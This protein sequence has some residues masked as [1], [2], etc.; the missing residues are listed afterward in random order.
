MPPRSRK[1]ARPARK[2]AHGALNFCFLAG[3]IFGVILLH[4]PIK[5]LATDAQYLGR[6]RSIAAS[7]G[8]RLH[9]HSLFSFIDGRADLDLDHLAGLGPAN[10]VRQVIHRYHSALSD[11]NRALHCILELTHIA[12]PVKAPEP[13]ECLLG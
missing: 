6:A 8:E 12:R 13:L 3:L 5:S 10:G 11:D 4:L 2:S 9:D 1:I 7:V